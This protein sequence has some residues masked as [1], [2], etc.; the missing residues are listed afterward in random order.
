MHSFV[1]ASLRT[2]AANKVCLRSCPVRSQLSS[3]ITVIEAVLATC[4]VPPRFSPVTTGSGYNAV[5]YISASFG[6]TNPVLE[7]ITETHSLFG[8][9]PGVASL[10]SL[11]TGHPGVISFPSGDGADLNRVMHDHDE[12][13]RAK[14]SRD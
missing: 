14:G 11:G 12:R 8:G 3:V 10:L 1:L 7:V 4:A 2:D 9:D 6:A 13:L 5:E